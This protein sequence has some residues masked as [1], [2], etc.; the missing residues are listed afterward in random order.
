MRSVLSGAIR[1]HWTDQYN[2]CVLPIGRIV[3][4]IRMNLMLGWLNQEFPALPMV[5]ILRH[6]MAMA[7]SRVRLAAQGQVWWEPDM[8]LFLD[9]RDL[10]EDYLHAHLSLLTELKSPFEQ[11]VASWAIETH[12]ALSQFSGIAIH[13]EDLADR[14]SEVLPSV[15]KYLGW[16]FEGDAPSRT[17]RPSVMAT[18]DSAVSRGQTELVHNWSREVDGGT[19]R[20]TMRILE[21][22]GLDALYGE[23]PRPKASSPWI[24]PPKD[25][26]RNV[27]TR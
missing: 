4:D 22:F 14:P 21:R 25:G 1:N 20:S 19:V 6:P 5:L 11:Q 27:T 15:Y 26:A 12:V 3:K 24:I 2:T 7:L 17:R 23:D 18:A 9:Q 8:G 13:Y 10:V 16:T